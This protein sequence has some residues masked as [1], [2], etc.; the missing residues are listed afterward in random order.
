MRHWVTL[1]GTTARAVPHAFRD[2][3]DQHAAATARACFQAI[4]PCSARYSMVPVN[5]RPKMT[6]PVPGPG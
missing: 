3:Q 1:P 4:W 5:I 6:R 2:G